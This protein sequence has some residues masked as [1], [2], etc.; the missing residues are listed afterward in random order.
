MCGR[1]FG[2][3]KKP[4]PAELRQASKKD[5]QEETGLVLGMR[6]ISFE[7]KQGK[8]LCSWGCPVQASPP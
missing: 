6:N 4:L 5:I 2:A 3:E 8:F 7:V 1:S